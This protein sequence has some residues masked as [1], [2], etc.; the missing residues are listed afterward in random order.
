MAE[1]HASHH[2]FP[3]DLQAMLTIHFF[4]HICVHP[5][6]ICT[7]NIQNLSLLSYLNSPTSNLHKPWFTLS[8]PRGLFELATL[9]PICEPS[10]LQNPS[11]PLK[12]T[13]NMSNQQSLVVSY[14]FNNL[15][16]HRY[17]SFGTTKTKRRVLQ[18]P[19][20]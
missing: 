14:L 16:A 17:V 6:Q 11:L 4:L 18:E 1:S 13:S 15:A 5:C 12:Y 2:H 10:F 7:T 3:P 9:S 8:S 19:W 20:A